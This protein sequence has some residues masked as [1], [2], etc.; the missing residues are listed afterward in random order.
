MKRT[1]QRRE[2]T[3]LV[4]DCLTRAGPSHRT[5]SKDQKNQKRRSAAW[6]DAKNCS[7]GSSIASLIYER[8]TVQNGSCCEL[9]N[10]AALQAL[11]AKKW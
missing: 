9:G 4:P 3:L 1:G 6:F 7:R 2:H 11:V 5:V 10:K 8:D